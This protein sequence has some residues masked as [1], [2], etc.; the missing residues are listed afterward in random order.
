MRTLVI[1]LGNPILT[2]D[3]IGFYVIDVL[4]QKHNDVSFSFEKACLAGMELLDLMLD[5]DR[6]VIV[7]AIKLG[8]RVG[9]VYWLKEEE[10]EKS[11]HT[12]THDLGFGTVIELGRALISTRMPKEIDILAIEVKDTQTFSEEFSPELRQEI[13]R[14]ISTIAEAVF[15]GDCRGLDPDLKAGNYLLQELY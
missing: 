5:T 2:D 12:A 10:I 8:G 13:P 15:R 6:L 9:R 11:L 14:I 1:G 7:D 4:Q 3:G